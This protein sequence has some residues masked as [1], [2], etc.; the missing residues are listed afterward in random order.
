MTLD[1]KEQG[2]CSTHDAGDS[3]LDQGTGSPDPIV[4]CACRLCRETQSRRQRTSAAVAGPSQG[5][6]EP[7]VLCAA[8]LTASVVQVVPRNPVSQ[9]EDERAAVAGPSQG[10]SEPTVMCVA[11]NAAGSMLATVVAVPDAGGAGG[12]CIS[13]RQTV[14]L[15]SLQ[16]GH[17]EWLCQQHAVLR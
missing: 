9:T 10:V 16:A 6:S 8:R 12:L 13:C 11:A 2:V 1:C 15:G 3:A 7:T 14:H 5:V 4:T 17:N